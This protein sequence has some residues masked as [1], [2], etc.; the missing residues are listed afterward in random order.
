MEL[1]Y[2]FSESVGDFKTVSGSPLSVGKAFVFKLR[3]PAAVGNM[4]CLQDAWASSG[5]PFAH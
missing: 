2:V 1:E 5:P 4:R 3:G